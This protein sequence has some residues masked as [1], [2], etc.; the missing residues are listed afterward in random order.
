M[1]TLSPSALDHSKRTPSL[2]HQE[3]VSFFRSSLLKLAN[4][5]LHT[6]SEEELDL[7]LELLSDPS[8]KDHISSFELDV[9][10]N[11]LIQYARQGA[12]EPGEREALEN[13]I[14]LLRQDSPVK[15]PK[16]YSSRASKF[17]CQKEKK[18]GPGVF[19]K[20]GNFIKKHKKVII[21]GAS[22]VAVA[23]V[24][25][26]VAVAIANSTAAAGAAAQ[27][28]LA[29]GAAI[30]KAAAENREDSQ[31]Q[32]TAKTKEVSKQAFKP[33]VPKE[34]IILEPENETPPYEGF[35]LNFQNKNLAP[36]FSEAYPAISEKDFL[37]QP[38]L[39]Q[40]NN[41]PTGLKPKLPNYDQILL[42]LPL[43]QVGDGI[44]AC[45]P[46]AINYIPPVVKTFGANECIFGQSMFMNG[47]LTELNQAEKYVETMSKV[48][49][50]NKVKLI[51]NSTLGPQRDLLKL[52][53]MKSGCEFPSATLL[54][55]TIIDYFKA[56]KPDQVLHLNL[57]SQ[58]GAIFKQ[59]LPDI[60]KDM[61]NRMY[62]D[63]Y[64][65]A[66]YISKED[67]ENIRNIWH[68]NDKIS[69]MADLEGWKRAKEEGTLIELDN[70]GKPPQEAHALDGGYA[71][72]IEENNRRFAKGVFR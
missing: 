18:K 61:R 20:I 36:Y 5:Q 51:Y 62:V 1:V 59:I 33:E 35:N 24:T 55:S 39:P 26:V 37:P 43:K 11:R 72:P 48:Q 19:K 9:A 21:I 68:P 50:G 46:K 28:A 29:S 41:P 58:A 17:I 16:T 23:A 38:M 65:T 34:P 10:A 3:Q 53:Y 44:L 32:E 40:I 31:D 30:A 60:P 13:G 42:N 25:A 67:V 71:E 4:Y 56:A 64:G 27:G 2:N 14:L 12:K 22:V 52:A 15:D 47:M 57:H 70:D 45:P 63:T 49:G 6:V 54:K 69:K 7:F 66:G 8:M